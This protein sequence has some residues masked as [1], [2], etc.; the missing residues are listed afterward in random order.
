MELEIAILLF[1]LLIFKWI[2]FIIALPVICIIQTMR[3]KGGKRKAE[4]PASVEVERKENVIEKIK[5]YVSLILFSYMRYHDFVVGKIPSVSVRNFIYKYV[6]KV[7]M[8]DNVII[9]F[10]A[11]IRGHHQVK[12]GRYTHIGDNCILDA[13]RGGITIGENVNFSSQVHL[14]T[15]QHD[16]N[17]PFFRSNPSKR[18]PIL[19][20]DR[21]W[22]GPNVTILH[23]VTIGEGAVVAAGA[24]VTKDV[25][26]YTLVGGVPAKYIGERNHDLRYVLKGH[27]LFY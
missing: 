14:W 8:K 15:G 19:I 5:G 20:G 17:D 3:I 12:I 23:S 16:Y 4:N 26:P 27:T 13:R 1:C 24:V 7:D 6:Y 11:E 18:G 21:A 10:G 2:I 22:I 25:K 9:H